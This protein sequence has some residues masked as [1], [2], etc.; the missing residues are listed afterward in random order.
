MTLGV[1][2]WVIF[3]V[4]VVFGGGWGWR[5]GTADT[6]FVLGGS[7]W[8]C[9]LIFLLGWQVFDFILHK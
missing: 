5:S 6:R 7:V 3:I 8:F 1:A 4:G 9:I 2:F